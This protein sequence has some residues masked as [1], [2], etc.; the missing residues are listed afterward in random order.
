MFCKYI[1]LGAHSQFPFPI[2]ETLA[3]NLASQSVTK[4]SKRNYRMFFYRILQ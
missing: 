1:Y 2:K 4:F 3:V